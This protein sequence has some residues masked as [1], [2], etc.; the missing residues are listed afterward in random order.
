[1]ALVDFSLGDVGNLFR[2][3][4]EAVT[5]EK[6]IDPVKQLEIELQLTQLE[7]ALIAGQLEINK[8]E[9]QNPHLFVSGWRPYIGW[10][11]GF[12]ITYEFAFYPILL[13][14]N[15]LFWNVTPPPHIDYALLGQLLFAML[16][17]AGL[18]TYEKN[19]GTET[20]K[21]GL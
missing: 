21:V 13:W 8:A 17:V 6:I 12:A 4:R 9:A 10:V 14:F 18:R 15:E 3:I 16:G 5:G 1:M 2:G 19:K 20:K 7:N 11:C